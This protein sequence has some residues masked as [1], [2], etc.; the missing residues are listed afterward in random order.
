MNLD[1]LKAEW[2]AE[3]EQTI[4]TIDLRVDSIKGDVSEIHRVVRLRDFWM[5]FVLLLGSGGTV[6]IRWLNGDAVGWLSQIGALAFAIA[7]AVVTIALVRA[8]KV[9]RSDDWT[10]R[11]RLESEI[12]QLEK[13]SRLGDSVGSW[14]SGPMLP[15]IVLL[16]LG[17]Y[18]D[19]T[20]S[21]A[22]N[23]SLWVYYFLCV[24]AYAFT[25]WLCRRE[26][27]KR[28]DPLLSRLKQ[29]HREL[30]G[31]GDADVNR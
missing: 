5:I 28:L 11:A 10:L 21:Y 27:S 2:R 20:G 4:R 15:A 12:E 13:Q 26:T 24:A 14:L 19:R 18:H 6:F 30:V 25:Y 16:S 3:M 22:P 23:L 1:D 8:R 7:S 17:G 29:L 31:N 9:T